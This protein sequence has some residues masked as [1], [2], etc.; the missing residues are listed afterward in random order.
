MRYLL[1]TL[2]LIFSTGLSSKSYPV[3][4]LGIEQGLSN[5]SI[6]SITQDRDGF[7]W[8]GTEE[9]LNK[10]DGTR[11]INYYKHTQSI[12][13]NELN[14]IY[15][16]PEEPII[17]IATQRAGFNAYNYETNSL[18]VYTHDESL[19]NSLVTNDITDIKPAADGNL[20]IST[21][22]KGIEYFNKCTG[23]FIHY[24]TSILPNL[25]SDNVWTIMDDNNEK[26]YIG[27]VLQGMSVLS[28][29]D[30]RIKN[31]KHNP[32]DP[33]SIPSDD[34]RCIYKDSNN[35]IWVGTNKGLALFNE[36]TGAFIIP[37]QSP[38]GLRTSPVFEIRQMDDNKLWIG[39]ELNGSISL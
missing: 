31:Y 10:F 30:K 8:F 34:V 12:S 36:E 24:N 15:A 13:G 9:G 6:V 17:W 22:H 21:Y 16:D 7:L 18:K 35:N 23:E 26:L 5:N 28:L 38:T 1:L 27:H 20:W 19:P 29:K 39:T 37:K 14:C 2:L 11:F 25:I 4:Q 32:N 3:V 33:G